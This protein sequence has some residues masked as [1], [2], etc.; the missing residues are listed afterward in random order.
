M[1]GAGCESGATTS[2]SVGSCERE[3]G[4]VV[5]AVA[6][7]PQVRTAVISGKGRCAGGHEY[8]GGREHGR[9]AAS[10]RMS[11]GQPR[12]E[13]VEDALTVCYT[14][15]YIT[16]NTHSDWRFRNAFGVNGKP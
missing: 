4:A 16:Y 9:A 6:T 5:S 3:C 8:D 1:D 13:M 7:R 12:T 10:T 14:T 2:S 15:N 11:E